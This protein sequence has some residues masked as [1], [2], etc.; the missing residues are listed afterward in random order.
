MDLVTSQKDKAIDWDWLAKHLTL[1]KE[2]YS[3][4]TGA[5]EMGD[6]FLGTDPFSRHP[7]FTR[8]ILSSGM[9]TPVL[10]VSPS[11]IWSRKSIQRYIGLSTSYPITR[12]QHVCIE[13]LEPLR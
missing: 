8:A 9:H 3:H 13:D 11:T 5:S 2:S 12:P 7:R 6:P 4:L 1:W 10:P